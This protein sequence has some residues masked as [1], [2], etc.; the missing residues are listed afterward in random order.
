MLEPVVTSATGVDDDDDDD[1]VAMTTPR[2]DGLNPHYHVIDRLFSFRG[3][4]Q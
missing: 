2:C 1:A 4:Q 3:C